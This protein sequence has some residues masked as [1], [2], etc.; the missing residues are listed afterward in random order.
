MK[1]PTIC[2]LEKKK[3]CF[4]Y[5]DLK[6]KKSEEQAVLCSSSGFCLRFH[7]RKQML[8]DSMVGGVAPRTRHHRKWPPGCSNHHTM[9]RAPQG[10]AGRPGP[11]P[12]TNGT[13]P[14]TQTTI[15]FFWASN[16]A[17]SL[18]NLCLLAPMMTNQ[19]LFHDSPQQWMTRAGKKEVT[20]LCEAVARMGGGKTPV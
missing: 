18:L 11:L 20:C 4:K 15:F 9:N 5:T 13:W 6:K 8:A 3:R 1:N 12:A 7:F 2:S 10:L 14:G 17:H 19:Q 16:M